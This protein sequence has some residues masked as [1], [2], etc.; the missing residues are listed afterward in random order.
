V[1]N[2]F[3][4]KV[5]YQYEKTENSLQLYK[6][7]VELGKVE[8]VEAPIEKTW[9]PNEYYMYAIVG[10]GALSLILLI[11]MI[12]FIASRKARHEGRKKKAIKRQE[13]QRA[14]EE[15][16]REKESRELEKYRQILEEERE[17]ERQIE[18]KKMAKQKAKEEKKLAKQKK[19]EE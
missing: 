3:G 14:K 4:E 16:Q 19:R 9:F 7:Y 15:R 1:L 6:E 2:E 17:K 18:E 13:K 12:Y 8:D 5:V 11:A 10:L